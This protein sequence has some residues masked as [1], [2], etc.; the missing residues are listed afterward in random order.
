MR[1]KGHH[2]LFFSLNFNF[3]GSVAHIKSNQFNFLESRYVKFFKC[4]TNSVWGNTWY[5]SISSSEAFI[6]L[7]NLE[8]A[9]FHRVS[10]FLHVFIPHGQLKS[11]EHRI[12]QEMWPWMTMMMIS[13]STIP[14]KLVIKDFGKSAFGI[15]RLE[16]CWLFKK[17]NHFRRIFTIAHH[18][19]LKKWH[20]W[21]M[22]FWKVVEQWF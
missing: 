2:F 4:M 14:P 8:K 21:S 9:L 5:W 7:K 15:K 3:R 20:L 16:S 1:K 12:K 22:W 19:F 18:T 13:W 10:E 11:I 17:L 6:S